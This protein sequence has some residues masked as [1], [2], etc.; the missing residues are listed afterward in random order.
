MPAAPLAIIVSGLMILAGGIA[1]V[2]GRWVRPGAALIAL[3]L[4]A[5]TPVMHSFWSDSDPQ[6]ARFN[7][8]QFEKNLALL[9][10]AV[11][12]CMI[13]EPWAISLAQ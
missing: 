11:M 2:V 7:K 5:V 6:R 12:L 10:A 3:F 4:V 1:I 13:S 8:T 9:G